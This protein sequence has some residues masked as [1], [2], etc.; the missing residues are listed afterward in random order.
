MS[1]LDTRNLI[2]FFIIDII[3]AYSTI[4][5]QP[6]V[7]IIEY[8]Q[9]HTVIRFQLVF[10]KIKLLHKTFLFQIVA[11]DSPFLMNHPTVF[12]MTFYSEQSS[13]V[14]HKLVIPANLFD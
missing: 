2:P 9:N 6:K 4:P 1:E 11:T 12:S 8:L 10:Q 13:I 14:F 3:I 7:T 5:H